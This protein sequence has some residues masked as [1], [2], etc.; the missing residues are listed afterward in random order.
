MD[1]Q[2]TRSG[3]F[4]NR[5]VALIILFNFLD[6]ACLSVWSAQL[7]PVLVSTLGGDTAVGWCAAASGIAQ[8][9][10]ATAA[11]YAGDRLPRQDVI[12]VGAFCGLVAVAATLAAVHLLTMPA[13]YITQALWG[14]YT[15]LVLTSA[16]ALF[17]D[18]VASGRR[19]F[20]YNFKWI[21]QTV[22]YC[23]GYLVALVMLLVMGNEW[24]RE[25]IQLVMTVGLGVH[26]IA[27]LLLF[28]L[29][30]E[31]ALR[32]SVPVV[33]DAAGGEERKSQQ[34][35]S[36]LA[37]VSSPSVEEEEEEDSITHYEQKPSIQRNDLNSSSACETD[38]SGAC[39]DANVN[40]RPSNSGGGSFNESPSGAARCGVFGTVFSW[41]FSLGAVPYLVCFTDFWM[42]V[43]SGMTVQY[44]TLFLVNDLGIE[45]VWLMG[46]YIA[47][48]CGAALCATVVRYIGEHYV[49]RLPAV[50]GVRTVGTT[51]LLL[52]ALAKGDMARLGVV[53]VL[54]FLR[55]AMMNSTMGITRSVIMD[56]VR[57]ESRAKW[58]AFES[59]SSFTW[60]GSAVVG[61][62]IAEAKGYQFAFLVTAIFHYVGILA[63]VPAAV[64]SHSVEQQ[65]RATKQEKRDVR[66]CLEV[67]CSR[68]SGGSST[69]PSIL[70]EEDRAAANMQDSINVN[71]KKN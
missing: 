30:D 3:I 43:G 33:F 4:R 16:E 21:V 52:L 6:G 28:L 14:V 51:F 71:P 70:S 63:L 59:F 20:I 38:A 39:L 61:G 40:I 64:A 47:I 25:S 31:Y 9:V 10:G 18:S 60:A 1:Y 2:A 37:H 19:A 56:C 7:F 44:L 11:G 32:Q 42:A 36:L 48:S 17:A 67:S 27:H 53:V 13:F 50:V 26:P 5:N 45:P 68:S 69:N 22:C 34:A 41:F 49:G 65:I 62:Y 58:S 8:I 24:S 35:R 46:T 57:K 15:G 29:G 66:Q 54:F 55:N 12:R 23:V